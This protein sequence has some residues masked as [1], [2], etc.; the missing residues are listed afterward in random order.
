MAVL[1]PFAKQQ[2]ADVNGAALSLGTVTLYVPGTSTPK[3]SWQ[4]SAQAALNTNP[5][6]LDLGGYATIY[7]NGSYRQLVKDRL[8]NI[9]WDRVVDPV[10]QNT[11]VI[12]SSDFPAYSGNQPPGPFRIQVTNANAS[13]GIIGASS[14]ITNGTGGGPPFS[15]LGAGDS[16][17]LSGVVFTGTTGTQPAVAGNLQCRFAAATPV[18]WGLEIDMNNQVANGALNNPSYGWG[19]VLN[20][21]STYIA[22][23]G[24][25][26]QRAT[27]EG[28]GPGFRRGLF[29]SGAREQ[30]VTVQCMDAATFGGMT[31]AAPSTISAFVISKSSEAQVRYVQ[32]E[33]GQMNWGG[34]AAATDVSLGRAGA[35][36]LYANGSFQANQFYVGSNQVVGARQTATAANATDLAT[37]L[38]LVN[39]LKT[40]LITHGLIS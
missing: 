28:S 35:G 27:G 11:G 30:G 14:F 9:I 18:Q 29:I 25:V 33:T 20:T 7:G 40:K 3:D 19:L 16:V 13:L 12:A 8:G 2:F 15:T 34:G 39:D 17:A 26:V 23:T 21:G 38:T 24:I 5:I 32:T 37:A 6:A 31:P 22:D 1:L 4:D 36:A 10:Q